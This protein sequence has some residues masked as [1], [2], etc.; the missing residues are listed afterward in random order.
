MA[1]AATTGVMHI[2]DTLDLGGTET[3]TVN[4][5]NHLPRDRYRPYVCTTR[6]PTRGNVLAANLHEGVSYLRLDR[7]SR[8]DVGALI[9]LWNFIRAENIRLLHLH[10][11]SLFLGR[12]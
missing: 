8:A 11:T 10:S 4:L 9:R 1:A 12:L 6:R 3:M 5:A 7:D 2:V